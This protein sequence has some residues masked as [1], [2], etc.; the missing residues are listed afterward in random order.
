VIRPLWSLA[1]PTLGALLAAGLTTAP[2]GP[3]GYAIGRDLGRSTVTTMIVVSVYVV[4]TA[5]ATAPGYLLGRRW[6]TATGAPA[7]LLFLVGSLMCGFTPDTTVMTIG[8]AVLGLGAGAVIGVLLALF[9]QLDRRYTWA[10]LVVGLAVG[11]ALLVGPLF[12]GVLAQS[13]SWRLVFLIDVPLAGL[14][15]LVT[16]AT[17]IAMLVT[18]AS[19]PGPPPGP[20]VVAPGRTTAG[21]A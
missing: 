7:H 16:A 18:R 13:A 8:C 9:G 10:R 2:L 5:A 21:T 6:P 17:G 4:A 19:R 20:A 15:L 11:A 14:A 1:G 12:A 3:W